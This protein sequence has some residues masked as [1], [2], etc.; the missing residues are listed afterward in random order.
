[1]KNKLRLVILAVS[2]LLMFSLV[3]CGGDAIEDGKLVFKGPKTDIISGGQTEYVIVRNKDGSDYETDVVID[4]KDRLSKITGVSVKIV[5]DTKEETAAEILIGHARG[6][7]ADMAEN[8]YEISHNNGKLVITGGSDK[9]LKKAYDF[10][11]YQ[12]LDCKWMDTELEASDKVT[13]PKTF[14]YKDKFITREEFLAQNSLVEYMPYPEEAVA[15]DYDYTVKITQGDKSIVLPVYNRVVATNYFTKIYNGDQHRRF[16]EFAFSGEPVTVEVTANIDFSSVSV[17]P[18]IDK[19][20]FTINGNVITYTLDKPSTTLV[21]LNEDDDTLLTIFAE[22]PEYEEDIPDPS[23]ENVI[24]FEPGYHKPEGGAIKLSSGQTLYLAPGALVEARLSI[25]GTDVTVCGHGTLME[26]SPNRMEVDEVKYM[27]NVSNASRINISGIKMIDAHT[28]NITLTSTKEVN[29]T[30]VKLLANQISTDGLSWWAKNTNVHVSDCFFYISDD[31]FVYGGESAGETLIENCIIGSDYGVFTCAV[32][33]EPITFRNND[34]FKC[35][36]IIKA[37]NDHS[38]NNA[39]VTIED[40][41]VEDVTKS[42][43]IVELNSKNTNR[44]FLL[45]DCSIVGHKNSSSIVKV[46]NSGT[47]IDL[48]LENVWINGKEFKSAEGYNMGELG[49]ENKVTFGTQ[50]DSKAANVG[51]KNVKECDKY[52]AEKVYIADLKVE[53]P[54][55]SFTEGDVRYVSVKEVLKALDFTDIVLDGE[56]LTFSYGNDTY[57]VIAGSTKAQSKGQ[58]V[59]LSAAPVMKDGSLCVPLDFFS[60]VI[61]TDASYDIG[62]NRVNINNINRGG[63]LLRNPG[64][65]EGMTTDW[66]TRWFTP[67]YLS[68]DAHSGKYAMRTYVND[69]V[70]Y[71]PGPANGIY[72]DVAD[73]VRRYGRGVYKLT[74]YVKKATEATN[75]TV[76]SMGITPNYDPVASQQVKIVPT[77]EWQK[78]E[79]TWTYNGNPAELSTMYYFVGYADG[80]YKNFLID[81]MSMEKIK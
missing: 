63:N 67:M 24:Y 27:C 20:D 6:V 72:Q 29:I 64:I 58:E 13:V 38:V 28:F 57:E 9:A 46:M 5:N 69:E 55:Q 10:F 39:L 45:K 34:L 22:E 79:Y 16:C 15:R 47:G 21:R 18:S 14:T 51:I 41:R 3:S 74:A 35:G 23:Y 65:E 78:L 54:V 12:F 37:I 25:T 56:K 2:V 76:I 7:N 80:T 62:N 77:L 4:L 17:M 81:D 26:S 43:P 31:V 32:K 30:D 33:G 61:G 42:F 44:P 52:V 59:N 8:E 73:V 70:A 66:V 60:T 36:K 1:M 50:F 40:L 11:M 19:H 49:T 68:E 53:T 48:R 71:Q 75:S